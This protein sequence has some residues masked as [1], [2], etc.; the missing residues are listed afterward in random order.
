MTSVLRFPGMVG[1]PQDAAVSYSRVVHLPSTVCLFLPIDSFF[2]VCIP[3]TH[4]RTSYSSKPN[5]VEHHAPAQFPNV[6]SSLMNTF[7]TDRS[8]QAIQFRG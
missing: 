2:L 4:A 6:P 7:V 5:I 1:Q 3:L 8:M